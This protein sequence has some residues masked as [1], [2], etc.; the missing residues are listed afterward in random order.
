MVKFRGNGKRGSS[1]Q[2]LK[3]ERLI[4]ESTPAKENT[5]FTKGLALSSKAMY[6]WN[7]LPTQWFIHFVMADV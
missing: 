2:S 7:M 3:I 4:I 1:N 5:R 6:N